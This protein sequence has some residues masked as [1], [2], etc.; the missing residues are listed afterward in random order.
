MNQ[1]D[2]LT[3]P[4][5]PTPAPKPRDRSFNPKEFKVVSLR[6]CPTAA[7]MQIIDTPER[8]TD[9]WMAHIP[10]H[11][12]FS[13]DVECFVVLMLNTRRR[14]KGHTLISTGTLDT[15]LVHPINVFRPAVVMSSP[16]IVLMHNHPSGVMPYPVLCRM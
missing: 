14:I 15:L 11:P 13:A 6:E 5:P 3:L 10:S 9:Y 1:P 2:L 16:A 8:A 7:D 12:Y 4:A